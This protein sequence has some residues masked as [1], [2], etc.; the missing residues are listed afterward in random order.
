MSVIDDVRKVAQDFI[1]P[2][3]QGINERLNA[4]EKRVDLLHSDMNTRFADLR[5]EMA[6]QN[7]LLRTDFHTTANRIVEVLQI[8]QRL[9][10]AGRANP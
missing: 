9:D 8:N 3:L 1:A 10:F 6:R 4:L 2:E 5:A 7:D